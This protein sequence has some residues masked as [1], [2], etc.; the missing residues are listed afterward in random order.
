VVAR[1]QPNLPTPNLGSNNVLKLSPGLSL[2]GAASDALGFRA[3]QVRRGD[4]ALVV[5]L[6]AGSNS[7]A[8]GTHNGNLVSGV[9]LLG[10]EGRL[11]RALASLAAALLLGEESGDP[12]VVDEV[13]DPAEDAENNE[14]QEDAISTLDCRSWR[15]RTV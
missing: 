12:G 2:G 9:D 13:G 15:Q 11:L 6:C 10:A 7:G 4:P 8:I 3:L 5:G 1:Q 14:V